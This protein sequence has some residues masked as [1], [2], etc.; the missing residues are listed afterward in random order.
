MPRRGTPLYSPGQH[1]GWMACCRGNAPCKGQKVLFRESPYRVD[2]WR[3][4]WYLPH[5]HV[6]MPECPVGV[7][8]Y[9]A[10]GNTWVDGML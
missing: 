5:S 10:Q 3:I 4:Y 7:P 2:V 1:P 6:M 8:L 9:I